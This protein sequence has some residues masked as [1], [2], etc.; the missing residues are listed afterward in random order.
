MHSS[1]TAEAIGLAITA[2]MNDIALT[3]ASYPIGPLGHFVATV[4]A[5]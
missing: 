2:A 5:R 1:K 4:T 3:K